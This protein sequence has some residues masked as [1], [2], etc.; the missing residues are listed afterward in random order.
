[1]PSQFHQS[2]VVNRELIPTIQLSRRKSVVVS[3]SHWIF[4]GDYCL[5]WPPPCYLDLLGASWAVFITQACLKNHFVYLDLSRTLQAL[6]ITGVFNKSFGLSL[7]LTRITHHSS[8]VCLKNHLD[9]LCFLR[10][11]RII[12]HRRV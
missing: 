1:M 4:L 8:Q 6:F 5:V 7:F 11:L 2:C 12:H 10:A 9:Y 3:S